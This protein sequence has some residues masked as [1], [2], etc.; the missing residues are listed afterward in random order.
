MPF[1]LGSVVPL[2]VTVTDAS[3]TAADAGSVVLTV[4]LPDQTT[5]TPAVTNASTGTYSAE[6]TPTQAGRHIAR[7]VATGANASAYTD[8]FDVTEA[9]V[10][11]IIS[12]RDAKKHL[13]M[14]LTLT[15]NDDEL[16][17]HINSATK[18]VEYYVGP[19]AIRSV[20]QVVR[21]GASVVLSR[22]PVISL[23]SVTA[24]YAG[25]PIYNVDDL[26][27]DGETGIVRHLLGVP[28][29]GPLR[30][31]YKVGRTV[32]DA[33]WQLSARIIVKHLWETQ[34]GGS[35]R[36]G[37]GGQSDDI[38]EQQL[39]SVMGFA[40]PRRA[41]ELLQPDQTAGIA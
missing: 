17:T 41:V 35:R 13:N 33:N 18:V 24:V 32:V 25:G 6:Y 8:V 30:W 22:T 31:V 23:T 27:L 11:G 20:T 28:L 16:R 36:P 10:A 5:E 38:V 15:T 12:L 34:R 19:V 7:W 40:V 9:A 29:V 14:S 3:G 39:V 2:S 1:D 4:T 21:G 26:D 37:M